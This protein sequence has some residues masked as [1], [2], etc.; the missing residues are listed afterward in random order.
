MVDGVTTLAE[1]PEPRRTGPGQTSERLGKAFQ[2]AGLVFGRNL[3]IRE[4]QV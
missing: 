3:T 1:A 4:R 2:H